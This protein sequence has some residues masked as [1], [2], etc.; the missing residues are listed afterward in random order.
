MSEHAEIK[1]GEHTEAAAINDG[2]HA[3]AHGG[4]YGI[5]FMIWLGLVACTAITVTVAGLNLGAITLTTALV[6]AG[7]KSFLV[8][9]YFMHVKNDNAMIKLF[10]A[11][12]L[13]IFVIIMILTF[14]D[15]SF[16]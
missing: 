2:R 1:T 4:G 6:I 3:H 15:L 13:L 11:V 5:Y 10:I 16:R 7:V 8:I 9:T 12:C 14:S